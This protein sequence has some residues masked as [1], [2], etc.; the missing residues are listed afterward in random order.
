[1]SS[2]RRRQQMAEPEE[3]EDAMDQTPGPLNESAEEDEDVEDTAMDMDPRAAG[4]FENQLA[5]KLVRY[6]LSCEFSRTPIRRQAIREK[7]LGEHPRAFRKVFA[8]AQEQ[9]RRTFGMEMRQL[10]VREK[11]TL[12]EKRKVLNSNT[13]T[14]AAETWIL[15]STLPKR[16]QNPAIL[17]PSSAPTAEY[18][19]TYVGFYTM[20]IALIALSGGE[21]TEPKLKRH[22]QRLNVDNK[23]GV[24]RTDDVLLKMEKS[25]YVVRKVE[26]ISADHDKNVSWLVGPR[27]KEEIGPEGVAGVVREVF[28]GTTPE[29]ER[30]LAASL[31]ITPE[32]PTG[33]QEDE[34]NGEEP[35]DAPEPRRSRRAVRHRDSD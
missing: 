4:G 32:E 12:E 35:E 30:K 20:V 33:A 18:E 10:P 11:L 13:Q 14:K 8:L 19:A 16:Y 7:V 27:G 15:V 5:K 34:E 1:M 21:I 25:G 9:L 31:G 24:E 2:R 29:L 6:A 22:F 28:G 3:G 26:N 17:A 23:L